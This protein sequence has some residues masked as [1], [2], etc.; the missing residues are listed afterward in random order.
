MS[1]LCYLKTSNSFVTTL[2]QVLHLR[3]AFCES[4]WRSPWYSRRF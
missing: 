3:P 2:L 4:V 1:F